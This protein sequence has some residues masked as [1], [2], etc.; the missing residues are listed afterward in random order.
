MTMIRARVLE[1][2][3]KSKLMM[4]NLIGTSVGADFEVWWYE[5]VEQPD[6]SIHSWILCLQEVVHDNCSL[7]KVL[8]TDLL[9]FTAIDYQLP[10]EN[11]NTGACCV[12]CMPTEVFSCTVYAQTAQTPSTAGTSN[13]V[14]SHSLRRDFIFSAMMAT[15]L[16]WPMEPSWSRSFVQVPCKHGVIDLVVRTCASNPLCILPASRCT[17][18]QPLLLLAPCF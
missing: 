16:N 6:R 17:H 8:G 13:P 10:T 9:T 7:Y 11:Q 14:A 12:L 18:T 1:S 5:D 15:S 4:Q 3:R 2:S